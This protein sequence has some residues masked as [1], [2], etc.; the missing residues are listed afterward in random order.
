MSFFAEKWA[1]SQ[2]IPATQK[3][4][5]VNLAHRANSVAATWP[6]IA[7]IAEDTG[8]SRRTVQYALTGLV[9]AGLITIEKRR[10]PELGNASNIY[11][12][13]LGTIADEN[14][15]NFRGKAQQAR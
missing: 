8:L 4:V 9:K 6:S 11:V 12:L 3:Y 5:L 1:W 10:H 14:V 13:E 2:K 7:T 15:V